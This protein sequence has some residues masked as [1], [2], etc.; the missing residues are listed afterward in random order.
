MKTN[1]VITVSAPGKIHVLGEHAVVY[2]N[3][4][5]LAA[6][7][8][9]L[10]VKLVPNGSEKIRITSES[11]KLT[12]VYALEKIVAL[13]KEAEQKWRLFKKTNESSFLKRVHD[14]DYPAIAIGRTLKFL[15]EHSIAGFDLVIESD[16]PVGS[17]LGSSSAVAVAVSCAVLLYLKKYRDKE[18]VNTIAYG[19][20]QMLHGTPSGGDNTVCCNGGVVVFRKKQPYEHIEFPGTSFFL[21]DSG[22]PSESTG[23]MV[24][25]VLDFKKKNRKDFSYFLKAQEAITNEFFLKKNTDVFVDLIRKSEKNLE[26]IGVVSRRARALISMVEKNGGGAKITGAGGRK[27]GSGMLLVYHPESAKLEKVFQKK[28]VPYTRVSLSND[29]VVVH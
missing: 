9:R 4:A 10:Q 23:E 12:E 20:E 22:R 29:G 18:T 21:I 24:A 15:H 27:K 16:I 28:M 8:K 14:L 13:T 2:G 5:L 17:G 1:T 26:R 7:N 3:A 11:L 19:I 6:I 25:Q